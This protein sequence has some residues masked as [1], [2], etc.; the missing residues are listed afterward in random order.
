MLLIGLNENSYQGDRVLKDW[1]PFLGLEAIFSDRGME[2]KKSQRVEFPQTLNL[3]DY[4]DLGL[5]LL[6]L[7]CIRNLKVG[8]KG[9]NHLEF[10]ESNRLESLNTELNKIGFSIQNEKNRDFMSSPQNP[11]SLE[12]KPVF[13]SHLDHRIAMSLS[14]LA[15][16][17]TISIEDPMVVEKS[18]PNYWQEFQKMGFEITFSDNPS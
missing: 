9:L 14:L 15:C 11:G 1:L 13:S 4:P 16:N 7:V 10:K 12:K 18:F 8:I 3:K 6:V 5:P 2:L 17:G